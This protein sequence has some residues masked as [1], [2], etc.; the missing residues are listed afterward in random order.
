MAEAQA[1]TDAASPPA[2][3]LARVPRAAWLALALLTAANV[4]NYLDRQIV[5]ILGQSIKADLQLDDAQLGFL[6]GTAFAIF[7][8]V[9]GIA[10]GGIA[11]RLTR[12]KVMASGLALWSGMTALGAA[13][14]GF[15]SL[16][17]ARVGVGI[18]EAAAVPCA[19]S[20][21]ADS[22]PPRH[23]TLAMGTY[24]SAAFIGGAIAMIAGG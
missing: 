11:D 1:T 21:V 12:K 24:V 8:S 20:L 22:F 13:A 6:L 9:V 3:A 4:L 23:R 5:S 16:S 2:A 18:G 14:T 17:I 7:Y 19:Q 15:V 10:M